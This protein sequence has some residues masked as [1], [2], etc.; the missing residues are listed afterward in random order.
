MPPKKQHSLFRRHP[1]IQYN[2]LPIIDTMT[3]QVMSEA[4]RWGQFALVSYIPEPLG[5]FFYDLRGTLP[6]DSNPQAHVTILPPRPLHVPVDAASEQTLRVLANFHAFEIEL[7]TVQRFP[8]TN[9]LYLDIGDG[10]SRVHDLHDALNTGDLAC[11]EEF[12]FRPHLTLGGPIAE[13]DV[14][15]LQDQAQIAW[16]ATGHSK[17]FTL[18][19]IVFLWLNPA[20]RQGEWHRLWSY[21]LRTKGTAIKKAAS[22]A[23]TNRTS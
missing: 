21:N 11:A 22:A 2:R 8:E 23:F 17:R 9:F 7:S 20:N 15:T 13:P 12:E 5:S 14:H 16:L 4:S 18:D 6:G 1:L 3:M 10:N 19:E